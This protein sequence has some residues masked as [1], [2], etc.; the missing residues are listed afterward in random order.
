MTKNV[1]VEEELE[2]EP[3]AVADHDR[4]GMAGGAILRQILVGHQLTV[5]IHR[6][7]DPVASP[8]EKL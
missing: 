6:V 4:V 8:E 5:L 1:A 3:A 7:D 2:L